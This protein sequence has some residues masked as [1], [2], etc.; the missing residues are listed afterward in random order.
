MCKDHR[1]SIAGSMSSRALEPD[2]VDPRQSV[3][4]P[5]VSFAA[6]LARRGAHRRRSEPKQRD[7]CVE[8]DRS[9]RRGLRA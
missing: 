1:T 4:V 7:L 8:L 3:A 6:I 9:A 5:H 2:E